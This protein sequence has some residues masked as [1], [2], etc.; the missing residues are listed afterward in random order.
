MRVKNVTARL[1]H[2]GD[3]ACIP[4]QEA[5]IPEEFVDSINKNDLVPVVE[6]AEAAPVTA[7]PSKGAQAK[8]VKEAEEALKQAT[9]GG[10]PFKIKAAE[11][12]LAAVKG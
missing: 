3:V 11:E 2:V 7:K 6:S 10:D 8:A 5:D 4:G 1:I 12:A 9:E